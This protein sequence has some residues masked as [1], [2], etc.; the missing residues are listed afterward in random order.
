MVLKQQR[1]QQQQRSLSV[2][3]V[4]AALLLAEGKM[5]SGQTRDAVAILKKLLQT[6]RAAI[7]ESDLRTESFSKRNP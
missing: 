7:L 1:Q 2:K 4:P 6:V 3:Q 5:A